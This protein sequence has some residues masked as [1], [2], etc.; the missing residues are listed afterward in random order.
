MCA[1]LTESLGRCGS[2]RH[3]P[4]TSFSL[5]GYSLPHSSIQWECEIDKILCVSIVTTRRCKCFDSV[6][7]LLACVCT[8][9]KNPNLT[10]LR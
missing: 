5:C 2:S 1:V 6:L 3:A 9:A 10:F 8:R 4:L 7:N